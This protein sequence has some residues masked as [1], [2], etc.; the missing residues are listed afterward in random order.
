MARVFTVH[1]PLG[2]E[3]LKF[4]LL[5]GQETLSRPFDFELSMLSP[6]PALAMDSLLGKGVTIEV[7]TQGQGRR[8]LHGEVARFTLI[9]RH[10]RYYRYTARVVPWLW[11]LTRAADFR[12]FQNKSVPQ[13][14]D[15]VFAAYPYPLEKRL[16][17][18]Y[19]EWEYCVQYHET[20]SAFVG[21][22][23]EEEGIHFFLE[24]HDDR[25]V[26]VL[27]DHAGRTSPRP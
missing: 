20:D 3:T 21:R 4:H 26:M 10:G 9:G 17:G 8:Y 24:H 18:H 6:S 5:T 25:H 14:L 13:I 23:L 22:L 12:I 15:E 16:T 11:Y 27:A 2:P 1:T 19:R 7:E